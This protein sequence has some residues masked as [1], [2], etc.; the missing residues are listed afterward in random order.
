MMTMKTL[1]NT[2]L[3]IAV[4]TGCGTKNATSSE[5]VTTTETVTNSAGATEGPMQCYALITNG[6]TVRLSLTQRGNDVSGTLHYQLAGKDRNTGTLSG[7]MRGDT[8]LATYTFQ[9]EGQVSKRE[10]A[11]LATDGGFVEG[12]G[13]VQEQNGAMLFTPGTTLTFNTDRILTKTDCS[14]QY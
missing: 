3:V 14:N 8:L 5:T 1:L 6:D 10:V 7:Q 12:Y 13:P 2:L 9:S 4:L 11:F